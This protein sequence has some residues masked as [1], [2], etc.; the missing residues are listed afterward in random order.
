MND[1]QHIWECRVSDGVCRYFDNRVEAEF[2]AADTVKCGLAVTTQPIKV[3][4]TG[5]QFAAFMER[6]FERHRAAILLAHKIVDADRA[7]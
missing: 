7:A 2:F 4:T 5:K 3:P 1:D 6:E